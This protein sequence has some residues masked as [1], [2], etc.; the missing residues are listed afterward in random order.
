MKNTKIQWTSHSANLWQGCA[1]V[2]TGCK[3]CYAQVLSHRW[4]HD[5]WGKDKPRLQVKSVWDDLKKYQKIAQKANEIHRVFVGSMMDIFEDLMPLVDNKGNSLS[6]T[7]DDLRQ[8]FFD[9]VV[10]NSPN[11]LFLLLTKR[12]SNINKYIPESWKTNPPSNV[13]FGTSP[14][15]QATADALIPQ[16]LEVNG[17]KFLSVEPQLE[18]LS[19]MKWLS[20][21]SIDWVINGG[22]SG[23]HKRV[24]NTDWARKIKAECQSTKTP[25]FFKQI[26]GKLPI[27]SDL[28]IREF[29]VFNFKSDVQ[30]CELSEEDF[31]EIFDPIR[32]PKDLFEDEEMGNYYYERCVEEYFDDCY[33]PRR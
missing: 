2:H 18:E 29:P 21:G 15:N 10:P 20:V 28:M 11:L 17:K 32:I 24:F 9:E 19:L 6:I 14:V 12:A 8:R 1:K 33:D 23:A 13:M 30:L 27:P 25:F 22:E 16:L 26:D 31:V 4:G 7:T 5:I 3:N